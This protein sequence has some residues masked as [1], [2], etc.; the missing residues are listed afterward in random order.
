MRTIETKK[1][2][3]AVLIATIVLTLASVSY[4]EPA[5]AD[6][7]FVGGPGASG[8]LHTQDDPDLEEDAEDLKEIEDKEAEDNEIDID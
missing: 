1:M 4:I 6:H 3:L 5:A 2:G 7:K 8:H